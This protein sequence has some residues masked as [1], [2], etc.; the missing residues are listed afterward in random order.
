MCLRFTIRDL[1]WLTVVVAMVR[2]WA[3]APTLQGGSGMMAAMKLK[4]GQFSLF[5]MLVIVALICLAI[6]TRLRLDRK[7]AADVHNAAVATYRQSLDW[8]ESLRPTHTPEDIDKI[9][10][11]VDK[12][13]V[14]QYHEPIP[15]FP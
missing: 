7:H 6:A 13:W 8:I 2:H 11:S 15:A 5:T 4:R 12:R 1:L 10:Q 9:R 14:D 3:A